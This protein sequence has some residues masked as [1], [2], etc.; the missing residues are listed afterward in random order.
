MAPPLKET[1]L[2]KKEINTVVKDKLKKFRKS[3]KKLIRCNILQ[4]G[5]KK[6][7]LGK[8]GINQRH[9]DL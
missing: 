7:K 5:R 2:H 8:F 6:R 1:T 4:K 3:K 9:N